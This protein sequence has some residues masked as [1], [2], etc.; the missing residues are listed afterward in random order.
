MKMNQLL[1]DKACK[2]LAE[3]ELVEKKEITTPNSVVDL[4]SILGNSMDSH[5][6][7]AIKNERMRM[8]QVLTKGII[9]SFYMI[10]PKK[11]RERIN[12]SK[13]FSSVMKRLNTSEIASKPEVIIRILRSY[14]L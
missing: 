6:I 12:I 3:L 1:I 10:Q 14:R 9:D 4:S 13:K 5:N 7:S 11:S 8:R 2:G